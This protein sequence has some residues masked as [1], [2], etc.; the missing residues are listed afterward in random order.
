MGHLTFVVHRISHA[1]GRTI[2][3]AASPAPNM[4]TPCDHPGDDW[5]QIGVSDTSA[6]PC[7]ST[8]DL[9]DASEKSHLAFVC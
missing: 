9:S 1:A 4:H 8:G 3:H 2:C 6:E 7:R 5:L